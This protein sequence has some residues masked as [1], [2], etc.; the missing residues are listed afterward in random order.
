[1]T[2]KGNLLAQNGWKQIDWA[3]RH[4]V[5][6]SKLYT[7]FSCK[8]MRQLYAGMSALEKQPY[9][10]VKRSIDHRFNCKLLPME[11]INKNLSLILQTLKYVKENKDNCQK[12]KRAKRIWE[13]NDGP[14]P[15]KPD[16]VAL[17]EYWN[18]PSHILINHM[19]EFIL[20][21]CE[22]FGNM[23]GTTNRNIC[24]NYE[25]LDEFE[26]ELIVLQSKTLIDF[27]DGKESISLSEDE[28]DDIKVEPRN[29]MKTFVSNIKFDAD[30][31]IK[32]FNNIK[33][34][35]YYVQQL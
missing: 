1:M 26:V 6:V 17:W 25:S 2:H 10:A 18:N 15:I 27:E 29:A 14:R 21:K 3:E 8:I 16:E 19:M 30:T 22:A 28:D 13:E 24:S 34:R 9:S 12:Y 11:N 35:N 20:S 4:L 7:L 23:V 32:S 31:N 33:N 5:M